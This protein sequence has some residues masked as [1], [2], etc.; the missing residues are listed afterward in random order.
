MNLDLGIAL[1]V[2]S[3][4][5]AGF[6]DGVRSDGIVAIS[7]DSKRRHRGRGKERVRGLH[8]IGKGR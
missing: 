7:L 8:W 5:S 6:G 2:L 1:E 4:L 3:V